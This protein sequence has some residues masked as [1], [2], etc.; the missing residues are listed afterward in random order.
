MHE[1]AHRF[2][3]GEVVVHTSAEP[4]SA[5]EEFDAAQ[6]F[7]VVRDRAR[8]LLPTP[9]TLALARALAFRYGCDRV[10]FG[11]AMPLALLAEPLG[12]PSVA[13]THGHEMGWAALPGARLLLR[14][15]A[16]TTGTVTCLTAH[17]RARMSA[18][19]GP[20]ARTARLVPGVDP[21]LFASP[22][23]RDIRAELALGKRPLVLSVSR[24]VPRKGQDTLIRAL[25]LVRRTVP[26]ATLLIVGSGPYERALRRLA[27]RT[28]GLPGDAVVFA[29]PREHSQL[30]PYYAAADVFAM[31]CRTRRLGLEAEGL[32][33]VYL[34]A[35]AAGLPVI[36]GASGGAPEAVRDGETGHV[37]DGRDVR[38]VADRITEL[39]ADPE[40]AAGMGAKGR[41]W[42]GAEWSWDASARHL[43]ALLSRT[44]E[45]W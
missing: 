21:G 26:E 30:P 7:P 14:R 32:G 8:L 4:G 34:E 15:V 10:W 29:G 36:A 12:L 20:H 11:A 18:A 42:V 24:L 27:R 6:P 28:A 3:P 16:D 41:A 22:P 1:V 5:T 38:A 43:R 44:V 19:L 33:I 23:R 25:P 9:R 35:A 37:T 17:A 40:T 45:E 31:P 39:L 13:T 2:P